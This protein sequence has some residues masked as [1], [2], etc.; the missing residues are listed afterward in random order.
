M[1]EGDPLSCSIFRN[2]KQASIDRRQDRIVCS[3]ED[4]RAHKLAERAFPVDE[5]EQKDAVEKADGDH[6]FMLEVFETLV[7]DVLANGEG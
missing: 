1:A 7:F 5:N 2:I 4:K 3:S 6:Y